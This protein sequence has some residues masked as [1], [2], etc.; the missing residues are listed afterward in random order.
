MRLL[1][2]ITLSL[3]LAASFGTSAFA[4]VTQT[5]APAGSF[6]S[7][8]S[9]SQLGSVTLASGTNTIL[10][11]TSTVTIQDQGWGGQDPNNN[12]VVIGLF[13]NGVDIWGQHVAGGYH[14]QS[15]QTYDISTDASALSSLNAAL[16]SIDW[17]SDPTVTMNMFTSTIGYPGWSLSTQDA[18]FS[19]TSN[20]PEPA[21]MALLG[22]GLAGLLVSRRK[23]SK[24]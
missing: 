3:V 12:Q 15:T 1:K 24:Q 6:D 9:S 21:S 20:V 19:V 18:S 11:L 16:N 22:L 7:N 23:F 2:K 13:D 10:G 17:A 4:S 8:W 14:T 5:T